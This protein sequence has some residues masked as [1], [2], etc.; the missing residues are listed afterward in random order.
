MDWH[1]QIESQ[2][3]T[4]MNKYKNP[5]ISLSLMRFLPMTLL[6]WTSVTFAAEPDE[7]N[8][9]GKD[10]PPKLFSDSSEMQVTLSGPWRKIKKR[11]EQDAHYPA[12]LTYTG[13]DGAAH[14]IDVEVSPRGIS[15]RFRVCNF[16][17]LKI[18]FDKKKMK[19]TEFRGN[20]SLKLVTYCQT[21]TKYEQY[22]IKE[23]L[24]YRIYNLI[25]EYSY[26]VRP[27]FIEYRDSENSRLKPI[28]R[29]SF[30]I[31]D[32]DDVA[33]R[34]DLEELKVPRVPAKQLDNVETSKYAL[35]QYLVGNLDWAATGGPDKDKC[36]HNSR[37]IGTGDDDVPKYVIPY[38][39]DST[40]LVNAHYAAPPEKLK[41]RSVR[42]RLYRGFCSHN[43]TLPATVELYR[44][45]R[46]AIMALFDD[47]RRI[48]D[49]NR[50]RSKDYVEDFFKVLD[51]PRR[52]EREITG[53]CRG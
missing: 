42:Q 52:F 44:Q 24:A 39:F 33:K 35:F 25:T 53:K 29:F 31:E 8:D 10:K 26:R 30:L 5:R 20:K 18:H 11:I 48:S 36:C 49:K 51:D 1:V 47:N 15:R 38:D 14:T 43:D 21:N 13:A 40:G 32:I 50:K 46:S 27:L 7:G 22:Y 19:G 4:P 28:S 34:N 16:P 6:L 37:L 2:V 9:D 3:S 23:F 41:V 45:N 17:P 12:Q